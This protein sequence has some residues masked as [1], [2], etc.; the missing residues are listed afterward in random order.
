MA[1]E[2]FTGIRV[3][4]WQGGWEGGAERITLGIAGIS[5][6]FGVKP[7]LGVFEK[8]TS[9]FSQVVVPK[10]FPEKFVAY[11]NFYASWYLKKKNILDKFDIV[12]AHTGGAWKTENNF[13]VYHE[14]TNL[15]ELFK[16]LPWKSKL[17]YWLPKRIS[18][19]SLK[20]ADLVVSASRKCDAFLQR[21]GVINF[22]KSNTCVDTAVFRPRRRR[23]CD[24]FKVLF[25]GRQDP[26]KNF[27]NLKKACERIEGLKLLVAGISGK[28]TKNVRYLGWVKWKKLPELYNQADLFVLPSYYEG[29]GVSTLEALACGTPVLLSKFACPIEI[30]DFASRCGTSKS[31]IEKKI[32]YIMKNYEKIKKKARG[33]CKFVRKNFGKEKVLKNEVKEILRHYS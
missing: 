16:H 4:I 13:Y 7:V 27:N 32:R 15:D 31:D 30:G 23:K 12:F 18:I 25:V 11:N 19:R 24:G 9:E 17:A 1:R 33:G 21:H 28:S 20:N 2:K 29:F 5:K 26:I 14:A 22:I 3:L 6:K 10:K 8:G